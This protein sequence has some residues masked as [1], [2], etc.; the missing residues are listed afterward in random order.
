MEKL[1]K[2]N[3]YE[4][5]VYGYPIYITSDLAA[6]HPL[7]KDEFQGFSTVVIFQDSF[8]VDFDVHKEVVSQIQSSL[9]DE[10]KS[11]YHYELKAGKES[12]N[13]TTFM[14]I[15]S[16]LVEKN[17]QRDAVFI[18]IGGGVV[19][20]LVGF[21]S[22]T[23]YRGVSL[24]HIPTNVLSM[25]DSCIG[26]KTAINTS[27]HVNTLG[28]YKHPL[29]TL[30]YTRYLAK[31]TKREFAAGFSEIIKISF[32]KDGALLDSICE[33]SDVSDLINK[34]EIFIN[35][36]AEA[37]RYKLDITS[38]DIEESE[39]RLYLNFGHT[40]AHAIE[41]V[42]DLSKEEYY[43]HGEAVSLG[44]TAA[45]RVSDHLF[46]T[47]LFENVTTLLAKFNLPTKLSENYL[48]YTNLGSETDLFDKFIYLCLRDKKGKGGML[49]LILLKEGKP[50]IHKTRDLNL[51]R[52][53]FQSIL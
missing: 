32:L 23:Y 7:L 9:N 20:D 29:F 50:F 5:E 24:V 51:L 45:S 6:L 41:S 52:I 39:K 36:L 28:T 17:I 18:A 42:Q 40:F 12:K 16:W 47:N 13:I 33:I 34:D 44:I 14:R 10:N 21:L 48:N 30:M 2:I 19:G 53:G 8:L 25:C 46:G 11:L 27:N 15:S 35:I 22:S 31:L 3:A 49:R 26:G 43:R 1:V 37:I 4:N 38:G